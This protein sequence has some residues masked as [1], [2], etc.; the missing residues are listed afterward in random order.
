VI[1][2]IELPARRFALGVLWHPDAD[3]EGAGAPVFAALVDA[4]R[5]S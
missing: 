1:E 2:A 5:V 4:A 3:I